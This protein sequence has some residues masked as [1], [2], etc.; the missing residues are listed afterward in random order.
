MMWPMRSV[1]L[2]TSL[3][4]CAAAY[5]RPPEDPTIAEARR[6]Y[7]AGL[8]RFNL[9]EYKAAVEEFEAAYRLRPD[10]VFLFN[11]GQ[12]YRLADDPEQAL[13]FYKA[14][15]RMA[16]DAVNRRDVEERIGALEQVI[17]AKK[18]AARPPDQ[19]LPPSEHP[20]EAAPT[21]TTAAAATTTAPPPAGDRRAGRTKKIAGLATA[22][23]G[24]AALGVAVGFSVL[25]AQASDQLTHGMP[26]AMYDL[27]LDRR[28]RTDQDVA[29]ALYAVGGAAVA[30][31]AV[32]YVLGWREAGARRSFVV[33]P[34][35]GPRQ[36]GVHARV[37]F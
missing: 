29:I 23:G 5:A 7:E 17:A 15:L 24:V 32:L 10:P 3:L 27:D 12:S 16:P 30:A 33:A 11:L 4:V 37:R 22:A 21:P 1:V 14:Y 19:T 35:F 36:A 9:K 34:A 18:K 2:F 25:A 6:H 26:G 13:Y 20:A 31:G 28:G 8:A